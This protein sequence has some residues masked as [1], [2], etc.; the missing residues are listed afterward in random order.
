MTV[1]AS[2]H[3]RLAFWVARKF[4]ARDQE[5]V[6]GAALLGLTKA[7]QRYD[8]ERGAFSSLAVLACRHEAF[9]EV[10]RQR[11]HDDREAS[12][13]VQGEDGDELERPDLPH[14]DP[15]AEGDAMA[16]RLR[17]ALEALPV[18]ERIVLEARYGLTGEP[19]SLDAAGALIGC[20]GAWASVLERRGIARLRRALTRRAAR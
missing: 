5:A 12:L 8:P 10:L 9:R 16:G 18:R 7:A 15:T 19:V 11:K 4:H 2:E 1:D 20:S 17:E 13:F 6:A 3:R 14:V